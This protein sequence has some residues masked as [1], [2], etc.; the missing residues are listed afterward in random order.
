MINP[1]MPGMGA[2]NETLDFMKN[3]WGGMGMA[4]ASMPGMV[5]PPLSVEE[6]NKKIKDLKAVESWLTLN[7]HMLRSTIQG[8]EVQAATIG[9]LQSMGEQFSAGMQAASQAAKD[10][11]SFGASAADMNS[12]DTASSDFSSDSPPPF[13]AP[14]TPPGQG[15]TAFTPPPYPFPMSASAAS[16]A[17]SFAADA[18]DAADATPPPESSPEPRH[19]NEGHADA[20]NLAAPLVNAAAWWNLLQDQ[21]KQAVSSAMATEPGTT[22]ASGK[23]ENTAASSAAKPAGKSRAKVAPEATGS[24]GPGTTRKPRSSN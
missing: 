9:T 20:A 14:F 19:A 12:T 15:A 1:S 21:F 13:A 11:Q 5:M 16:S 22:G 6:I 18:A 10:M 2:M 8:L 4:G 3:L 23:P 24:G 7:M 17:S